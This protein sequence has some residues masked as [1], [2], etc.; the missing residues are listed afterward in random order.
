[1]LPPHVGCVDE[2]RDLAFLTPHIIGSVL[3]IHPSIGG[4]PCSR[5]YCR[6]RPPC[7]AIK[8]G[9][10]LPS[11]SA[12]FS[13][14]L[15]PVPHTGRCELN[16]MNCCGLP[17]CSMWMLKT[18]STWKS[19]GRLP[20]GGWL[21]RT[22]LRPDRGLL[23]PPAHGFGFSAG[24]KSLSWC[25]NF[26]KNWINTAGGCVMSGALAVQPLSVGDAVCGIS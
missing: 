16:V 8:M 10:S 15:I 11:E 9:R 5:N 21:S 14:V 25:M 2:R 12:I 1:M 7:G 22:R 4:S 13:I 3:V 17:G 20:T 24:G 26:R 18:A 6:P 19:W 23:M